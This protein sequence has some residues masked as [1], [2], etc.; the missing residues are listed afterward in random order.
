MVTEAS[1][2]LNDATHVL[3]TLPEKASQAWITTRGLT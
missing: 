1:G 2:V 3:A